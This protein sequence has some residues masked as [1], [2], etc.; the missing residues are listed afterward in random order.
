M[1]D[2]LLYAQFIRDVRDANMWI[3]EKANHLDAD[4]LKGDVTSFDDKVRKLQKHQAFL[5]ELQAHEC[6]IKEITDKGER[7]EGALFWLFL[8][9]CEVQPRKEK[10]K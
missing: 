10:K 8:I 9:L 1:E 3:D 4:R 5:A 7:K 6:S 2:A